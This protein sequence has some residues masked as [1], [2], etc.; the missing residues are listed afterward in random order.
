MLFN[1]RNMILLVGFFLL[2]AC[3]SSWKPLD[4]KNDG[5]QTSSIPPKNIPRVPRKTPLSKWKLKQNT[6]KN[7]QQNSQPNTKKNL[8]QSNQQTS[9]KPL[10]TAKLLTKINPGPV[11][12]MLDDMGLNK[13]ELKHALV[14]LAID[15]QNNPSHTGHKVLDFLTKRRSYFHKEKTENDLFIWLLTGVTSND[16]LADGDLPEV[17][18]F[19]IK[20]SGNAIDFKNLKTKEG[21][22]LD[23]L[24]GKLLFPSYFNNENAKVNIKKLG[25]V[26]VIG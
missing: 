13:G 21:S 22:I 4:P 5:K 6:K 17:V 16:N 3:Q 26:L 24:L 9:Q 25:L 19:F 18:D 15:V 14:K 7:L 8:Q 1:K 11:K 10:N 20:N 2:V 23:N 12:A